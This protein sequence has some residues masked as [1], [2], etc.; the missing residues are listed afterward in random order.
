MHTFI[1][2][3]N[4]W[5]FLQRIQVTMSG[6]HSSDDPVELHDQQLE[7]PEHR[8]ME[9]IAENEQERHPRSIYLNTPPPR[10]LPV[11]ALNEVFV[12]ESLSSR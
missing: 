1:I 10:V 12:G 5:R 9:H 6:L 2:S 3:V 4:R 7:F 8:F 11:L